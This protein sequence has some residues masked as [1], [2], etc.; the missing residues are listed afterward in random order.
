MEYNKMQRLN[1]VT[2]GL[3]NTVMGDDTG[4][5]GAGLP[6][7]ALYGGHVR[8]KKSQPKE[9]SSEADT[10]CSASGSSTRSHH[11]ITPVLSRCVTAV[12]SY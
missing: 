6:E 7:A 8:E 1:T 12:S 2:H 9:V 10:A 3:I 5:G 4:S 11:Q